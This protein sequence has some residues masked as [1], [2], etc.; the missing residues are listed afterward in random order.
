V[1]YSVSHVGVGAFL[2]ISLCLVRRRG[3]FCVFCFFFLFLFPKRV[4]RR[5]GGERVVL[6]GRSRHDCGI[7]RVHGTRDENIVHD[8]DGSAEPSLPFE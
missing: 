7:N 1:G 4:Y 3:H 2:S 5:E 8:E 6:H